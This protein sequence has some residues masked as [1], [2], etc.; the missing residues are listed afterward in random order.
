MVVPFRSLALLPWIN[1][2]TVIE[3]NAVSD[4][5]GNGAESLGRGSGDGAHRPARLLDKLTDPVAWF[6]LLL[7][8]VGF[9]QWRTLENT[10]HT[11][12]LQQ[13]AWINILGI[14]L[15]QPLVI[16]QTIRMQINLSNAGREPAQ[17]VYLAIQNDSID[18]YEPKNTDLSDIS[19]PEN[20]SCDVVGT[21]RSVV[22]PSTFGGYVNYAE[23]SAH[24]IRR[25]VV[26]DKVIAR[27]KYYVV[28][29]CVHYA[30]LGELKKSAFCYILEHPNAPPVQVPP[31]VTQS[32]PPNLI[33]SPPNGDVPRPTITVVLQ[34]PPTTPS[35]TDV[36]VPCRAGFDL[37]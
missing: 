5:N 24:G 14:Q 19:V 8:G 7:A 37:D 36:F 4:G 26:D 17:N 2:R 31:I 35:P 33:S 34:S 27:T 6:T 13:R 32:A 18:S 12:Q 9:L 25:Y 29:G 20:R 3:A 10:D 22:P 11:M 15:T 1:R 30:T 28:Q 16:D 23:D 21:V